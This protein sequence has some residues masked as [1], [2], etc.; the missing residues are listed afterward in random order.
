M[1][2]CQEKYG[3]HKNHAEYYTTIPEGVQER[4]AYKK[5]INSPLTNVATLCYNTGEIFFKEK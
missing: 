2:S 4:A 3:I 5:C 1:A